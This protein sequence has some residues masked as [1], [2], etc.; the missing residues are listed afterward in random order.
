MQDWHQAEWRA[1][2]IAT[3]GVFCI[4]D[5]P[6]HLLAKADPSMAGEF[7]Q[8][9]YAAAPLRT[10]EGYN[11][12]LL[13]VIDHKPRDICVSEKEFLKDRRIVYR[14]APEEVGFYDYHRWAAD[15]GAAVTTA[16]IASLQSAQLFSFVKPY[17]SQDQPEYL[18]TGRLERLDELDYGGSVRVEA[19]L[20]A[21]LM[22]LRTVATV[23]AGEA[24]DT[25]KVEARNLNSVVAAMSQAVQTNINRLVAGM[26][27]QLSESEAA[28]KGSH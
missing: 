8:R 23:W 22:N 4:T 10:R 3:D 17:D 1:K 18:L 28:S 9:F 2:A 13:S 24:T 11:I 26:K 27:E 7:G 5:A 12:G 15:P 6:D 25:T 16:V 19:K 20:S 21:E 14:E